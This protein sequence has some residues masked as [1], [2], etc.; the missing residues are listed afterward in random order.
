[1]KIIIICTLV[2]GIC[3]TLWPQNLKIEEKLP[4]LDNLQCDFIKTTITDIDTLIHKG[5]LY[6]SGNRFRF[7]SDEELIVSD[8]KFITIFREGEEAAQRTLSNAQTVLGLDSLWHSLRKNYELTEEET[9]GSLILSGKMKSGEV[10]I[11]RFKIWF[12]DDYLPYK[13]TWREFSNYEHE[14]QLFN[15]STDTPEEEVFIFNKDVKIMDVN[16]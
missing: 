1:M 15:I 12:G 14:I 2:F 3:L 10:N 8:G 7:E 13:A 9:N 4:R 6:I 5:K 11:K 16:K